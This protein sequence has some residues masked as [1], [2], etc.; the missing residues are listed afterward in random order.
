MPITPVI[1]RTL[2]GPNALS[3]AQQATPSTQSSRS[4]AARAIPIQS[5]E[6]KTWLANFEDDH[7]IVPVKILQTT[8]EKDKYVCGDNNNIQRTLSVIS[9]R[10]TLRARTKAPLNVLEK[11][12]PAP[13]VEGLKSSR[14]YTKGSDSL[15]MQSAIAR[16]AKSTKAECLKNFHNLLREVARKII[17]E[18]DDYIPSRP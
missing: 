12:V 10:S 1:R 6:T 4:L 11:Y 8:W 17:S 15:V 13:M 5:L 14:F 16:Q 2:V 9:H 7:E 3:I 18:E